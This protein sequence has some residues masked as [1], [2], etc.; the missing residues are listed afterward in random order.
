M[1]F[2]HFFL[3]LLLWNESHLSSVWT[4]SPFP[5]WSGQIW[6][7]CGMSRDSWKARNKKNLGKM[8]AGEKFEICQDESVWRTLCTKV[9]SYRK[10]CKRWNYLV[11]LVLIEAHLFWHGLFLVI[12]CLNLRLWRCVNCHRYVFRISL[13]CYKVI[14]RT[15]TWW[16]YCEDT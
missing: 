8:S 13:I 11:L 15:Y 12:W 1:K 10:C 6:L 5:S 4:L 16:I 7:L 14:G 9:P 2:F 3:W